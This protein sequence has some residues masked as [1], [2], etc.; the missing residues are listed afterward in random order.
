MTTAF[1][2]VDLK[3]TGV[4]EPAPD[5]LPAEQVNDLLP[6]FRSPLQ[7]IFLPIIRQSGS[8]LTLTLT[9]RAI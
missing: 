6:T 4:I 1:Y 8:T 3:R 2:V 7:A 5:T 9:G